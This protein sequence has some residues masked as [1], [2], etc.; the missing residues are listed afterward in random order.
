[1]AASG[2][3]LSESIPNDARPADRLNMIIVLHMASSKNKT[4]HERPDSN[5]HCSRTA[6]KEAS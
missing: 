5:S 4:V 2:I 6:K 3:S 1:V